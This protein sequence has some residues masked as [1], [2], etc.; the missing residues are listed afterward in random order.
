M[1]LIVG[2]PEGVASAVRLGDIVQL[3]VERAVALDV[4]D[5]ELEAVA[6]LLCDE[7]GVPDAFAVPLFVPLGV[8]EEVTVCEDETD[9]VG[10][11]LGVELEV[12]VALGVALPVPLLVEEN[13]HEGELDEDAVTVRESLLD[14]VVLAV[15]DM[16]LVIVDVSEGVPVSVGVAPLVGVPVEVDEVVPD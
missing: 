15:R 7:E 6:V 13:V 11:K 14:G 1:K 16:L 4:L 12:T 8:K 3:A 9:G 5:G 10:E 2:V